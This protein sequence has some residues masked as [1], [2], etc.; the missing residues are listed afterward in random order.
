MKNE[1]FFCQR[2][3]IGKG[4]GGKEQNRRADYGDFL[5]KRIVVINI[6]LQAADSWMINGNFL[7][8]R[9]SLLALYLENYHE[10]K[11]ELFINYAHYANSFP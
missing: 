9:S 3:D 7:I 5:W 10:L 4:R 6:I 11:H 2:A 8:T 1:E